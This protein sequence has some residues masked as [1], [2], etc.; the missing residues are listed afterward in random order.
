MEKKLESK[1]QRIK[2]ANCFA[3]GGM[4]GAGKSTLSRAL[5]NAL[6][7]DVVYE[8]KEDDEL[9]NILL[10]KLYEGDKTSAI[11]FQVYFFCARFDNYKYGIENNNISV[12]D[13]TIFEDR[14]FAHQNMTSDPIT[15]GF[16][17]SMWHD[18]TKELIYTVG[19]PKLYV[20]LDLKWEDFKDR[21]FRRGRKSEVDNFS[22]NEAY[23]KSIHSVYK[24]YLIDVCRVYGI[25]Y[26]VI[27]ATLPTEQQLKIIMK[28]IENDNLLDT[29][30][31]KK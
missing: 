11:A 5:G 24:D 14:L 19:V 10:K 27:D 17:D 28:R 29:N 23:F 13:R 16:Y 4:I 15:F 2:V 9:Q 30:I 25:N 26:I 6:N 22:K 21:I 1:F 3:V 18:K 31:I 20:I 12:F 8:L 7:A